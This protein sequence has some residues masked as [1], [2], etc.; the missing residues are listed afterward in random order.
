MLIQ[1]VDLYLSSQLLFQEEKSSRG[2]LFL[3]V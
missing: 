2:F 1:K 3:L